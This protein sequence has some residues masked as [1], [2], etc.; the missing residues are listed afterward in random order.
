MEMHFDAGAGDWG[1]C[2][3]LFWEFGDVARLDGVVIGYVGPH[4][5]TSSSYS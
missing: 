4:L 3:Q 1:D 2:V 5:R